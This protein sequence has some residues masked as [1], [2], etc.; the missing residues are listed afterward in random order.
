MTGRIH[1]FFLLTLLLFAGRIHAQSG[2]S[3]GDAITNFT[4]KGTDGRPVS[5]TDYGSQKGVILI[6]TSNHCPFSRTY[7]DRI[8]ALNQRFA[9]LGYPV[10]AIMANDPAAYEEDSFANMQR[11]AT[12]QNYSYSYTMD[13]SQ[14]VARR[15]GATRTPQAFVLKRAADQFVLEYMGAIDDNPQDPSGVQRQYV[16]DAVTSLLARRPVAT[17]I[18]KA[19]GCAIKL[20]S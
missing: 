7:E 9:P 3:L 12:E 11:R 20:R 2:Y 15:F 10:L 17:P 6:F 14:Q 16:S 8:Q 5:L 13:E 1:H 18:T 19:V 4:V